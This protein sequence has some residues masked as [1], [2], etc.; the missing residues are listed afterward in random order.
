MAGKVSIRWQ[1][2]SPLSAIHA[3]HAV[4]TGA[5]CNDRK[6]E[7]AL[8]GP[9]SDINNRLLSASLDISM[10]WQRL[11]SETL[12]QSPPEQACLI[13]LTA[14]GCSELQVEQIARVIVNRLGESR[15]AFQG[16]FPKLS[17]QLQLRGRPMRDQWETYGTGLLAAIAKLIWIDSPPTDWW[18]RRV[19]ALLVQPMRGGAGGYDA[20]TSRIWIE[21]VLT[22][23]DPAVPEVLRL[24]YLITQLA[25]DTHT[26]ERTT[27]GITSLPWS[28]A[29][30]SITLAA[31][32]DLGL[33][34]SSQN[35]TETA[36]RLWGVGQIGAAKVVDEW[37]RN[38]VAHPV[39]MPMALKQL[40]KQLQ[41]L[42]AQPS[43]DVGI[44][45][46]DFD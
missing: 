37:W 20:E 23:V 17:D 32:A 1:T 25:I 31:A 18:P 46:T 42:K 12:Y 45:L 33:I 24:A 35:A 29:T 14:S 26:L 30:I 28:I 2:D 13:A 10:F 16:R 34:N 7:Q 21:A 5:V 39:A 43:A 36:M 40:G 11:L 8:A 15:M 22:D 6:T 44:D 19:D 3:A 9:I 38:Q 41:P 4:A 27:D